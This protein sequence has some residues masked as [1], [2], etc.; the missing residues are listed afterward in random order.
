M[1][2]II[3]KPPFSTTNHAQA[4]NFLHELHQ[5]CPGTCHPVLRF[6]SSPLWGGR[7]EGDKMACTGPFEPVQA[8]QVAIII[9][10]WSENAAW[11]QTSDGRGLS[12]C[13]AG[14]SVRAGN[15]LLSSSGRSRTSRS[16]RRRPDR[17]RSRR[18]TG[19]ARRRPCTAP[20]R[21]RARRWGR[22]RPRRCCR[23]TG[24]PH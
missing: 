15:D 2:C 18:G 6:S 24:L 3:W 9:V 8:G 23:R 1:Y 20:C 17:R 19:P 10:V 5:A 4:A 22:R 13:S 7:S 14:T 16:C 12:V 11:G 21:S